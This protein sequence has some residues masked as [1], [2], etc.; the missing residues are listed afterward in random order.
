MYA[1]FLAV[2]DDLALLQMGMK[3]VACSPSVKTTCLREG[4]YLNLVDIGRGKADVGKLFQVFHS[5]ISPGSAWRRR[6]T[7]A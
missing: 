4:A 5:T 3:L 7:K 6:L 2:F 1:V